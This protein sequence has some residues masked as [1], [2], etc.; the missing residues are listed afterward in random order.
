M[1][2]EPPSDV[3][4]PSEPPPPASLAPVEE[5]QPSGLAL[6]EGD[7]CPQCGTPIS[8]HWYFCIGCALPYRDP[9]TFL[10]AVRPAP[11]T[12]EHLIAT[13]APR[14]A[15]LFWT[16]F[17]VILGLGIAVLLASE[18]GKFRQDL[19]VLVGDVAIFVVTCFFAVRHWKAL[20]PQF[21][22]PGFQKREAWMALGLLPLLLGLAWVWVALLTS[23]PDVGEP[24][25]VRSLREGGL[26]DA[27]LVLLI[28][29][30]PAVTEEIAFRGL[31]QHW[32]QVAV[33][34]RTAI[35][36]SSALFTA[37]H[38]NPLMVPTIFLAGCLLGWAKWKTGSLWPSMLI[39]F[40]HN[41]A[42]LAFFPG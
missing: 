14:V 10:P 24:H 8:R 20:L 37:L 2:Q 11:P 42:V 16:Y 33:R 5:A 39:H 4:P 30:F 1:I 40:L 35:L 32:L 15:P 29:V 41:A 9:E 18:R 23:I 25:W 13:K 3:P 7:P 38:F 36:I 19:W 12:T 28:A 6:Q 17:T 21:K 34:P 31:V 26:S 27:S 22:N